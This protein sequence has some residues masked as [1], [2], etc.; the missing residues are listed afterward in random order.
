MIDVAAK[1]G[2]ADRLAGY[3]GLSGDPG[4]ERIRGC[5]VSGGGG[6]PV[7]AEGGGEGGR[8]VGDARE[9]RLH[10]PLGFGKETLGVRG[11]HAAGQHVFLKGEE[12]AIDNGAESAGFDR[13][14]GETLHEAAVNGLQAMQRGF[15]LADLDFRGGK[16]EVLGALLHPAREKGFP[17]AVLAAH[18]F[19]LTA[20]RAH[21]F[22]FFRDGTFEVA[23]ANGKRFETTTR[24]GTGPEGIDD[25]GA[26]LW[27]DIRHR[28]NWRS[29]S[30]RSRTTMSADSSIVRMP[31]PS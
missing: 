17:A 2:T 15:G 16:A 11:I 8:K 30:G 31:Y 5:V 14:R 13:C 29:S 21:G 24:H 10:Q 20:A 26:A 25:I 6:A 18:G 12:P 19:E 22:Q 27:A 4:E 9:F 1:T 23:Q 28:L 3:V 7:A